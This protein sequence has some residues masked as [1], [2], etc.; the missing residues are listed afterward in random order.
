MKR[1]S[2]RLTEPEYIKVKKYCDD[3]HI[4]MNDVIRQIIREWTPPQQQLTEN[5]TKQDCYRQYN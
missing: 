3:L 2:L 4:S 1:F 5:K